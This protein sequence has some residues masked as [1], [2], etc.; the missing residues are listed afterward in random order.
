MEIQPLN[1]SSLYENQI[2]DLGSVI[3]SD[4]G[5][6]KFATQY[7][8]MPFHI[9]KEMAEKS[10]FKALIASGPHLFH[11]FYMREWMPRFK[12]TVFAGKGM[13][14][15]VLKKP[16]YANVKSHCKVHIKTIAPKPEKGFTVVDWY[17]EF[18]NDN[19]EILQHLNLI[20]LHH[21]EK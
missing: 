20:I 17:F 14:N 13:S 19:N 8:P 15:W 5:I 18:T 1:I 11:V 16:V 6:I 4:D 9:D 7:D 12:H 10:Y 3:L 21:I 2:I